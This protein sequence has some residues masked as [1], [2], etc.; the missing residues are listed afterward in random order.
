ML[1][2]MAGLSS[3]GPATAP[4][5]LMAEPMADDTLDCGVSRFC[6]AEQTKAGD[7]LMQESVYCSSGTCKTT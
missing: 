4:E 6:T 5:A 1:S 2:G 3:R 7:T